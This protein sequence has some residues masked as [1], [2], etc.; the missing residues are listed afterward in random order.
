MI[1]LKTIPETIAF[2][3]RFVALILGPKYGPYTF[4]GKI[5]VNR[6]LF[7]LQNFSKFR[8]HT[9]FVPDNGPVE[10]VAEGVEHEFVCEFEGCGLGFDTFVGMRAHQATKHMMFNPIRYRIATTQCLSCKVENHT[11]SRNYTHVAYRSMA[12]KAFYMEMDPWMDNQQLELLLERERKAK[13]DRGSKFI[14]PPALRA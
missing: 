6:I 11:I 4:V 7:A 8:S 5:I 9:T 10:D 12:C 2:K 1:D 14:A 3:L 13:K